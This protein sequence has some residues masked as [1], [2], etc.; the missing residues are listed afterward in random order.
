MSLPNA[1]GPAFPRASGPEPRVNSVTDY[2][3]G[4]SMRDWFAGQALAGILSDAPRGYS[5]QAV[6]AEAY[7]FAD[8]ML[9]ER[10]KPK[11]APNAD[12]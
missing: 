7:A 12:A 5:G 1:G 11:E 3:D 4:M 2:C 8:A 10:A 6:A 9:A